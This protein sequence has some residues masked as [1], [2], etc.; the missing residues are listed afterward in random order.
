M[1]VDVY[2]WANDFSMFNHSCDLI[3][4]YAEKGFMIVNCCLSH[5]GQDLNPFGKIC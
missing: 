2:Y 5:I 4:T 1:F 3:F